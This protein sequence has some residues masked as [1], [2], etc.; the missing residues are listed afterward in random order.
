MTKKEATALKIAINKGERYYST[1][2]ASKNGALR[3]KVYSYS[4]TDNSNY[5]KARES[6]AIASLLNKVAETGIRPRYEIDRKV[7]QGFLHDT[8]IVFK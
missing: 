6:R 2:F 4:G 8:N 3:V 7:Y 1:Y 5:D